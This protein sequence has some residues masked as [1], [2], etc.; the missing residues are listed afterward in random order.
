MN[1]KDAEKDAT[2]KSWSNHKKNAIV[3]LI[4][5]DTRLHLV[6]TDT[7]V[8]PS[9]F[10]HCVRIAVSFADSFIATHKARVHGSTLIAFH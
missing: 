4:K 8:P 3:E 7:L 9:A 5:L 10:S 1:L 2:K 6:V